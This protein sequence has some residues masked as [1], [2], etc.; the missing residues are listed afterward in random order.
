MV[1][2]LEL[3]GAIVFELLGTSLMK[4]SDGFTHLG[5]AAGTLLDLTKTKGRITF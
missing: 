1:H 3:A 5:Y 4:M 2:Y